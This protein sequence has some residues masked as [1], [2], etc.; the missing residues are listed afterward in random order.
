MIFAQFIL[1]DLET[2]FVQLRGLL[3]SAPGL[4]EFGHAMQRVGKIRASL[5][6]RTLLDTQVLP[7]IPSVDTKR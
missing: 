7:S 1:S 6:L 3:E 2:L 5:A 4:E